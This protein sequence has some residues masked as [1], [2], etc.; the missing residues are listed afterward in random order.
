MLKKLF[1][2]YSTSTEQ[3][4]Q[5]LRNFSIVSLST[6]VLATSLLA[7]FYRRQAVHDLVISTEE[8][9]ITTT[10]IFS[11]MLWPKYGTFLSSTQPLSDEELVAHP[12]TRQLYEDTLQSLEDSQIAKVKIFDLQGR[13]VFSTDESQTGDDKSQSSGF[14]AARSGWVVSQLNHRDTFTALQTTLEDRNLLSSYIPIRDGEAN[15]EIVGVF[16]LY[17]DVTPLVER[18]EQTQQ[19]IILGSLLILTTLYGLLYLFVKRADHLLE[20]QYQRV[21]A[22]EERYR[23]QAGELED[24]LSELRQAQLRLIQNEKMSSL[25]NMVAGVAH[26]IN[27]PV[28]FINGNLSHL[29]EYGQNLLT[30][31]GLYQHHY[32]NPKPEIQAVM[33]EIDL[34]FI[35]D[36]LPKILASMDVGSKRIREIVLALRI[37]SRLDEADIKSVDIHQG[38]DSTLMILQHRLQASPDR[39]AIQVIKDYATLRP[40]ECYA[41][42]LN[43]VFMN[44]LVNAIDAIAE[45]TENY[46]AEQH[47]ANPGR[48]TLQTSVFE[49]EWV[50]ITIADNGLGIPPEIQERIFEPFFTTK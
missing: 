31:L 25:G 21:Q 27:N 45:K 47:L 9:N 11:N 28:S 36:D 46:T 44:I 48:I 1:S 41:G 23:Q 30:V 4:F 17:T 29:R 12:T 24:A 43:Q 26:E 35:Q 8:N 49:Q 19:R 40:V 5:L 13:T 42:L 34:P 10:Q 3:R 16:E 14:L 7:I 37:F 22:S 32:P 20:Q 18:I 39:P 33:D 2:L 6:F 15:A 50:Q 38:L